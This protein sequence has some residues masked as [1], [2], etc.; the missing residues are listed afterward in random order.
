MTCHGRDRVLALDSATGRERWRK[1]VAPPHDGGVLGTSVS[2]GVALIQYASGYSIVAADGREPTRGG[3][4]V[5]SLECR[6]QTVAGHIV[7]LP[8]DGGLGVSAK[9][10][11]LIVDTRT[12]RTTV[13]DIGEAYSTLAVAGGR[14][15]GVHQHVST[16]SVARLLPSGL[17]V[18]DPATGA[19][20]P[21]PLPFATKASREEPGEPTADWTAVAGGRLYTRR[22]LDETARITSYTTTKPGGPAELGGVPAADWPD[23]CHLAP[24]LKGSDFPSAADRTATIG[25]TTLR[26][27]ACRVYHGAAVVGT[28]WV[29]ASPEQAHTLLTMPTTARKE[30]V[31]G[32]DE[33]YSVND[34]GDSWIR[35]GRYVMRVYDPDAKER[36]RVASEVA[37]ALRKR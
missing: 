3:A 14:V 5:C 10:Q 35:V 34:L 25:S 30:H 4:I 1:D 33:A 29:A 27:A 21:R 9:R 19:V 17:D 23:A 11:V 32:A 28:A 7:V 26:N 36:I 2:G 12:G 24:G 15:Y 37:K 18:I 6:L 31:D 8:M 20:R 22:V 16:A 13:S